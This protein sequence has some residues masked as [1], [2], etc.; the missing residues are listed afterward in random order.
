MVQ[1]RIAG[2]RTAARAAAFTRRHWLL[3]AVFAFAAAVRVVVAIAY[4]PAVFFSDSWAYVQMAFGIGHLAP[5]RPSGY[6]AVLW[7]IDAAGR[8]LTAVTTLQHVAGL[9][10]AGI[11]YALLR[12]L[13]VG[14]WA[15]TGATALIALDAYA[16]ALE[17]TIL[18]EAFF[19]VTLVLGAFL[20][21]G[22]DRGDMAVAGSGTALA[23]AATMRPV[24]LFAVPA[25]FAYLLLRHR[26]LRVLGLSL[27]ALL[28]PLLV[29]AAVY[30]ANQGRFGL[31][32]A[33]GWF[34]YGRV[35]EIADCSKFD[36]PAQTADLCEPLARSKGEGPLYYLWS[37]RSPANRKYGLPSRSDGSEPLQRF[38]LAVIR[39]RPVAYAEL[40]GRDF[41]RYFQ[42]GVGSR[43]E[44]DTAI[45]LPASPRTGPPWMNESVRAA[46]VPTYGPSVHA[47]AGV[48]RA[49][50]A[51]VHPPRPLLAVLV[52]AT[53]ATL[54]LAWMGRGV[55]TPQRWPESFLLT[56]MGVGMLFG[57]A[58]TSS[59]VVRY[60]VPTVP[61]I[62][63]GGTIALADLASVA[64]LRRRR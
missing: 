62:V 55:R 2:A 8:S 25:W 34:L 39:G 28:V 20:V 7:A 42:P 45:E 48:V 9:G 23:V 57:T 61:L 13:G 33:D 24:T 19:T 35:G 17:Q 54:A 47:P 11:S 51:I 12:R 16:I 26:R 32:K 22:K 59:F 58:L 56:G 15:A 3:I 53:V 21:A 10:T 50:G 41:L 14:R 36:P 64:G 31:T 30:D 46:Y 5:D 37:G 49:Y 43:G 29:Y 4:R 6:P 60:L 52:L 63:C 38:A 40:V 1:A 18:A 44:S 27:S